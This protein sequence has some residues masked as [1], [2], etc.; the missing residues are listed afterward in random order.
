MPQILKTD[1]IL[2][3]TTMAMVSFG[4]VILYSASSINAQVDPRYGSAWYFVIR[5]LGWAVAAIAA[6]MTLKRMHYRKM[7][8]PSVAFIAMGVALLLL[9]AVYFIDSAHHRW[10]RRRER[11]LRYLALAIVLLSTVALLG[12]AKVAPGLPAAI[13]SE[14]LV[15]GQNHDLLPCFS[16]LDNFSYESLHCHIPRALFQEEPVPR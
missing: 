10:L 9:V 7:Y 5:Q 13:L 1:R 3:V 14:V 6:M 15:I 2:F 12:R 4:L 11:S 8:N 16:I